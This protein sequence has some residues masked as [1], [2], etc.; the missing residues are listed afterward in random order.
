MSSKVLGYQNTKKM[1]KYQT[2]LDICF[3][4][5]LFY[6][7]LMTTRLMSIFQTFGPQYTNVQNCILLKCKFGTKKFF[8]PPPPRYL[9]CSYGLQVR[10]LETVVN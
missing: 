6:L 8:C 3:L 9:T 7:F 5:I 1:V 10:N 4:Y 2:L